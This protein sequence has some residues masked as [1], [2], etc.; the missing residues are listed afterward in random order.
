MT[1]AFVGHSYHKITSSSKWFID[2]IERHEKVDQYWDETWNDGEPLC[3]RDLLSYDQIFV[4]QVGYVGRELAQLAPSKVVFI[5]MWDGVAGLNRG[6]WH[7]FGNARIISFAWIL[8]ERLRTWG[9][10]SFHTQFFLDPS[11]FPPVVDFSTLRGYL[12]QRRQEIGWPQVNRLV[13][14]V[15]WDSFRLHIGMDPGSGEVVPPTPAERRCSNI[16]LTRFTAMTADASTNYLNS[17]NVFFASRAREGIGMAFLEAMASGMCVVAPDAPTMSEYI[18]HNVSGLLYD[19][20]NLETLDL[21]RAAKFGSAARRKMELGFSEWSYDLRNRLPEIL[22]P[23]RSGIAPPRTRQTAELCRSEGTPRLRKAAAAPKVSVAIVTLNAR[24]EFED[25]LQSVLKQ[26][27]DDIEIVVVDGG[28]TDGTL[29]LIV[30]NASQISNWISERDEGPYDAM[31]KAAKL[32]RGEY[33]IYMNAGDY[34]ACRDA[35]AKAFDQA[36]DNADFIIGHHVYINSSGVEEYRSAADFDE[37]WRNL[38]QGNLSWRWFK[39]VPCHQSTITRRSLLIENGGYSKEFRITADHEFIYRMKKDGA[40]FHHC[41][42]ILSIYTSGG[43]SS[44]NERCCI[45]EWWRMAQIYGDRQR[46]DRFFRSSYPISYATGPWTPSSVLRH[47]V[48]RTSSAF[49]SFERAFRKANRRR[50]EWQRQRFGR[51]LG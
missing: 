30:S 46:V 13:S 47:G 2:F 19:L 18:D 34:F 5:P 43:F 36:P 7:A 35:I 4:W 11:K 42:E 29:E 45:Q 44:K 48:G 51:R 33:I 28:S 37:T 25:T 32:A 49:K 31:N 40:S 12:W 50:L 26:T 27:F 22:F 38:V 14:E 16:S 23:D 9:L 41:G 1:I 20:K 6:W 10:N 21:S 39:G 24:T 17:A 15:H 8:H 3:V